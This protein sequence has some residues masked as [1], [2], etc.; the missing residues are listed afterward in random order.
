MTTEKSVLEKLKRLDKNANDGP[1]F[2]KPTPK[3]ED[4]WP[5]CSFIGGT[6]KSCP[7]YACPDGGTMPSA[8][9]KLIIEM[10][11]LL[12]R[13]IA[14]LELVEAKAA[15]AH[16]SEGHSVGAYTDGCNDGE[17]ECARE[18]LAVLNG[19]GAK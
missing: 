12:P 7:I 9:Q 13:L 2:A 8:N 4:G 1:W 3:T 5:T 14:A 17:L 19:E 16:S 6:D 15:M 18:V 11:N 10:R